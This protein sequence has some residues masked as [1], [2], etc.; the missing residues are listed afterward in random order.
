MEANRALEVLTKQIDTK[1][2]QL[3]EHISYGN[4]DKFEE[5]KKVCGEINGLLTARNYITDL[6]KAMENSDE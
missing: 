3:Q 5:Y 2:L 4:I 1:I 6:N